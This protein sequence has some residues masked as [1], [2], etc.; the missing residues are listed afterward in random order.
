MPR[1][2]GVVKK[3]SAKVGVRP[4]LEKNEQKRLVGWLRSNGYRFC[5]VP[6]EIPMAP[7][8]QKWALVSHLKSMGWTNGC[9][10]LFIVLKRGGVAFLEL[11]RIGEK[12][13]EG[14][15]QAQWIDALGAA[16]VAAGWAAGC[17]EAV[18]IIRQWEAAS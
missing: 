2:S 1:R 16:G 3:Q 15:E 10:D 13:K 14:S 11:K 18:S 7:S 17:D 8:P 4:P 12:V 5:H 6:S 9:P